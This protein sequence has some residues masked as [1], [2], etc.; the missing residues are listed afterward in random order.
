MNNK[1]CFDEFPEFGDGT[2]TAGDRVTIIATSQPVTDFTVTAVTHNMLSVTPCPVT[3]AS[4]AAEATTIKTHTHATRPYLG[5]AGFEN[6]LEALPGQI[7]PNVTVSETRR[8]E[9]ETKYMLTFHQ[10][11]THL[12]GDQAEIECNVGG[13][14]IDGCQPR[15][16]GMKSTYRIVLDTT[17]GGDDMSYVCGCYG[18]G[19]CLCVCVCVRVCVRLRASSRVFAGWRKRWKWCFCVAKTLRRTSCILPRWRGSGWMGFG[20]E[21]AH[22]STLSFSTSASTSAPPPV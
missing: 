10:E 4:A 22:S 13:C 12:S 7:I 1:R 2:F 17:T 9:A 5:L 8:S 21:V 15:Y 11:Y 6:A 14:D 18:L 3:V 20:M 16:S 19:V